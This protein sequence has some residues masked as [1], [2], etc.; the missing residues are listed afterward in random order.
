MPNN[1]DMKS[2]KIEWLSVI[3]ILIIQ[4][5]SGVWWAAKV[6]SRIEVLEKENSISQK[7]D[8]A[9][10]R[11]VNSRI[12][13]MEYTQSKTNTL[14]EAIDSKVDSISVQFAEYRGSNSR[15]TK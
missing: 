1:Q 4:T 2:I 12:S 7:F 5:A 13:S 15:R 3:L 10:G 8:A 14:L 11:L 9:D 6:D